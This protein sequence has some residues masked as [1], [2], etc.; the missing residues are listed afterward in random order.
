MST[1]TA[2]LNHRQVACGS[3][4]RVLEYVQRLSAHERGAVLIFADETGR[5]IDFDFG[6]T[7]NAIPRSVGRPKLGVQSRE[8][9]L[10]PR[11]WEWLSEQSGGASASLR[12]LVDEAR[13]KGRTTRDRHDA[14]YRFMQALC[15]DMAGY[16]DAL[17]AIYRSDA[18][19][20]SIHIQEWPED[21]QSYVRDLLAEK[22][23]G[24]GE[25]G[26]R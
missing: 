18:A 20:L 19:G 11:H 15:G 1:F 9:T 23:P 3:R 7:G 6:Q 13:S 17:R 22:S 12:R 10:L 24:P 8:I 14:A 16:E 2:F 25:P 5:V 21:V 4:D 26:C